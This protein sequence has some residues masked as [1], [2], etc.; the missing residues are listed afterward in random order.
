MDSNDPPEPKYHV[1]FSNMEKEQAIQ[2][3][4]TLENNTE[5]RANERYDKWLYSIEEPRQHTESYVWDAY[6]PAPT[7]ELQ[8]LFDIKH[9]SVS[10]AIKHQ[11]FFGTVNMMVSVNE[12]GDLESKEIP[13]KNFY[14]PITPNKAAEQKRMNILYRKFVDNADI[15]IKKESKPMIEIKCDE[16]RYNAGRLQAVCLPI[17]CSNCSHNPDIVDNFEQKPVDWPPAEG[18]EVYCINCKGYIYSVYYESETF[19]NLTSTYPTYDKAEQA[20]S[21]LI[22]ARGLNDCT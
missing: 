5:E 1:T 15:Y 12:N 17:E 10:C 19:N 20:V 14:G 21:V 3:L 22:D 9:P 6:G 16:C 11:P 7:E 18:Q 4:M 2:Y 13:P 8:N